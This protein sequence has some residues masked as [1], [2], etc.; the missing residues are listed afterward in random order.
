MICHGCRCVDET[1]PAEKVWRV[2]YGFHI[3]ALNL[4]FPFT[5]EILY[6]VKYVVICWFSCST[7]R[8]ICLY[9]FH[10]LVLIVLDKK[11]HN[12]RLVAGEVSCSPKCFWCSP[13][14]LK[15]LRFVLATRRE[16]WNGDPLCNTHPSDLK[17]PGQ[18]CWQRAYCI[19]DTLKQ[20][21]GCS[22]NT[23]TFTYTFGY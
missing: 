9:W 12:F 5:Q 21:P 10:L 15:I 1:G 22:L 20:L 7:C 3:Q 16:W 13:L 18:S 2:Q 4:G 11:R 6:I 14:G 8:Q 19:R 23:Y 17:S